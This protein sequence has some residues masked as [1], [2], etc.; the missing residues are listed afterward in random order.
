[1][2]FE[3]SAGGVVYK[4]TEGKTLVL[5]CKHASYGHWGFPKGHIADT[6]AG[7]TKEEAA[8][9]EVNEETGVV[10]E[11]LEEL[12]PIEYWYNLKGEKRKKKVYFFLMKYISGSIETHDHE[13]SEVTWLPAEDVE[14]KLTYDGDKSVWREARELINRGEVA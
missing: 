12:Q 9:R 1:M 7:E 11:I 2:Q 8:L 3:F 5:M 13:M 4:R 14:E 6:V 10:A